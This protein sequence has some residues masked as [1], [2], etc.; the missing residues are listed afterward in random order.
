MTVHGK[1]DW[2]IEEP[3]ELQRP[4][5]SADN[6]VSSNWVKLKDEAK[7]GLRFCVLRN[8]RAELE[9]FFSK[10]YITSISDSVT[11]RQL[12]AMPFCYFI[13]NSVDWKSQ[14][15]TRWDLTYL[16]LLFFQS[17]VCVW[18][19][20]SVRNANKLLQQFNL[21]AQSHL[22]FFSEITFCGYCGSPDDLRHRSAKK[23]IWSVWII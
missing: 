10:G 3:Q 4:L 14:F 16:R 5:N 2:K 21:I 6:W 12:F 13:W 8:D 7:L 11:S 1:P 23:Y 18:S 19:T 17:S 15:T 20:I 9:L 22:L